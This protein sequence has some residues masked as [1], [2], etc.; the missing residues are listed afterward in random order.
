MVL[1][2]Q[3]EVAERVA[4]APGSKVYGSLSVHVQLHW[5]AELALAVPPAGLSGHFYTPT[6]L[7]GVRH[8]RH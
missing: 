3:R 1:M 2:L 4:A 8:F 5:H 6:V 7:T